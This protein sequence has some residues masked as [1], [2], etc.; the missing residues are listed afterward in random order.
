MVEA[1]GTG[2]DAWGQPL[3][4]QPAEVGAAGQDW[5]ASQ[6]DENIAGQ[7]TISKFRSSNMAPPPPRLNVKRQGSPLASP[8][9]SRRGDRLIFTL[10]GRRCPHPTP[11][12]WIA[13]EFV[14]QPKRLL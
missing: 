6:P 14:N 1:Q 4:P 9:T 3:Q 12:R 13:C 10:E 8:S 7:S 2:Q 5:A 11:T